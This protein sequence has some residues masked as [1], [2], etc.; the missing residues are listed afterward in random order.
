MFFLLLKQIEAIT[1]GFIQGGL[2]DINEPPVIFLNNVQISEDMA[3]KT[4][5]NSF[6]QLEIGIS[7]QN[8]R[9]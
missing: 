6:Q 5:L 2:T 7:A 3:F 4:I 9:S 1:V 8:Q